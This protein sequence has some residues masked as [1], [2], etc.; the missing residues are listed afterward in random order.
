MELV[1]G[2]YGFGFGFSSEKEMSK[3]AP[4]RF[5]EISAKRIIAEKLHGQTGTPDKWT[6]IPGELR[7]QEKVAGEPT[8][9]HRASRPLAAAHFSQQAE[10]SSIGYDAGKGNGED[11]G[12]QHHAVPDDRVF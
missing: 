11:M 2:S 4:D 5:V 10:Q 6:Q 8:K 9:Q 3:C 7:A 1:V 12:Q